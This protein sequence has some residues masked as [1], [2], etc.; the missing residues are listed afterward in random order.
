MKAK[1]SHIDVLV[2]NAG[3]LNDYGR[4]VGETDVDKFWYDTSTNFRGAYLLSRGLIRFNPDDYPATFITFSTLINEELTCMTAY[5]VSKVSAAKLVQILNAEYSNMRTFAVLPG[6]VETEMLLDAFR[7][8][9]F[10]KPTLSAALSVWLSSPQ[11]DFLSGR[12]LDARWDMEQV[13]ARKDEIVKGDWLKLA[14]AGY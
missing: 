1:F 10:D 8:I 11:A 2:H 5:L 7:P 13:V 9:A 4:K 12:Y 3:V 14:L 6:V